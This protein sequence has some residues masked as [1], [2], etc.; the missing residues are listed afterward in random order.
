MTVLQS[1]LSTFKRSRSQS[2]RARRE[3]AA[4]TTSSTEALE[5]RLLLV[6]PITVESLPNAPVT[7]YLDFDGHTE[8]SSEWINARGDMLGSAIVTPAY[9][10]DA[11]GGNFSQAEIDSI[12]EIYERVA[13]DFRPFNINVTTVLPDRPLGFQ[14]GEDLLVS[15]GGTGNWTVPVL[16]TNS[17]NRYRAISGSFANGNSTDPSQTTFAFQNPHQ[18]LGGDFE[19][20]IAASV[21]A[22]IAESMGLEV[23]RTGGP[24]SP[25]LE[26]DA[27]IAP[28]LGDQIVG[29]DTINSNQNSERDIWFNAPGTQSANQDDLALITSAGLVAYRADDFGD[30]DVDSTGIQTTPQTEVITGVIETTTDRDVIAF[31]TAATL[32]NIS[33]ATLDLRTT[34]DPNKTA[35]TNLDPVLT[36]RDQSGAVLQIVD[37]PGDDFGGSLTRTV[38]D[39]TYYLEVSN[40]GEYGNLGR[41]TVSIDGVDVLPGFNNPVALNSKPDAPISLYLAFNGGLIESGNAVLN[42]RVFGVGQRGVQPYDSDGDIFNFTTTEL[43]EMNEIWARVAEDFAPFDVNVTTVRP[44]NFEDGRAMQVIV[45]GDG[46]IYSDATLT[47]LASLAAFSDTALDNTALA[48]PLNI[49]QGAA[50]DAKHVALAASTAFGTMLGLED[51]PLYDVNGNVVN[52]EDPGDLEVGPIMGLPLGSLRDLWV[53][54]AIPSG[55]ADFQDDLATIADITTNGISF[56]VDD[57]RSDLA[58]ATRISIDTGTD[59]ISG[60]IETNDD[61]DLFRFSTLAANATISVKGLDLRDLYASV[62]NP[63]TNLDP[64]LEILDGTGAVIETSDPPNV[65]GNPAR[66]EPSISRNLPAGTYYLRVSNRGEYGNLGQ[67]TITLD[68]VDGDPVTVE[69]DPTTF[70]EID[71]LQMGVGTVNR[72]EGQTPVSPVVVNLTSSDTSELIVPNQVVIP[73]GRVSADF[74]ITLVDD[75]LLDGDQRVSIS[76]IVSGVVNGAAFVTVTDYETIDVSVTPN[77]V[78]EDAGSVS[79][80]LTRSNDDVNAPNHWVAVNNELQEFSPD[81]TF[82]Q[83]IP[84]QWPIGVRPTGEDSHDIVVLEDGRIAVFNGTI[85]AA[86]SIYNPVNTQWQH[87]GPIPGLSGTP[88]DDTVGGIASIGDYVFLTDFETIE[89]DSHGMTRINVVTG[90]VTRFGQGT[91][92]ARLFA[93][94]R[95]TSSDIYEFNALDGSLL[96]TLQLPLIPGSLFRYRPEAIAFDGEALWVL[97]NNGRLAGQHLI[98]V[99]VDSG[100][101][102]DEHSLQGL[103]NSNNFLN[104]LAAM[105]GLLYV[106]T[107]NGTISVPPPTFP[108]FFDVDYNLEVEEYDPVMRRTTGRVISPPALS[109]DFNTGPYYS[110][111]IGAIPSADSI[112]YSLSP[113]GSVREIDASTSVVT[114]A[115]APGAVNDRSDAGLTAISDV[116]YGDVTYNDLVFVATARNAI[117]VFTRAGVQIDTDPTTP[118]VD[119]LT[120]TVF[121]NGDLT[122]ADVPGVAFSDLRFRDVTIGLDGL[123]YGLIDTGDEISVHDPETLVRVRG[124][125]LDTV[126]STIGVSDDTGIYAGASNGRVIQFDANGV[127]QSLLQ[128]S[129]GLIADI[130]VNIGRE[131]LISDVTGSVIITTQEAVA[132]ADI[133]AVTALE[134]TGNVSFVSFGRHPTKSTGDL[135]VSLVSSDLTELTVPDVVV[136]PEGQKSITIQIPVIDD[137]ERDGSQSVTITADSREY[138]SDFEIVVVNDVEN[139]GIDVIPDTVSETA[140]L[141]QGVVRVFRTDVDGPLDFA[142]TVTKNSSGPTA[143]ADNAVSISQIVYEDQ[144]SRVTDVNVALTIEH[145]A[146][147]DLDVF[148]VSPTGTRVALF[149]D[150]SSNESNLTNTTLDDQA[151]LG[152]RQGNAPFTG[153]FIPREALANFTGENPSGA[154]SLEVIDDSITDAGVLVSWSLEISTLGLGALTA[155]LSSSHPTEASIPV[156]VTIPVN[157]AEIFVPLEVFDDDILEGTRAV[158]MSVDS[159]DTTGFILAND[160]VDI[161]DSELLSISLDKNVISESAGLGAIVGTVTRLDTTGA[162]TV[163]LSTSDTTE[164]SVPA[165]VVIPDGVAS[166]TFAVDAVDDAEFDNDQSATVIAS[167]TGYLPAVSEL[168]TIQDQEP[169]LRLS[170]LTPVVPEDAGTITFTVTRLDVNDPS[171]AQQVSLS[172]SDTSELIVPSTVI[173]PPGFLS[174]NFQATVVEDNDL[175]GSQPVTITATDINT[176]T[177]SVN[178]TTFDVTIQDA[179]FVGITVPSGSEKVLENAG[180]GAITATVSISSVGHTAPIVV[181]LSNSDL[182]ELSIPDEVVILVG[183]SST[184][185]D[186][187]VLD[188]PKIDRDQIATITGRVAGYRDG[189]LDITVRDHEPPVEVGPE[190]DTIDPTPV[191]AWAAVDGATRYDLW[192]ND[193]SRKITQLFRLENLP[194]RA[195]IFRDDFELTDELGVG[196][197]DA[198]KWASDNAEVDALA[199]NANGTLSAHLNGNPDGGDLLTSTPIDLSD[200]IGAQ[201][202]YSYQRTGSLEAPGAGQDLILQYRNADGQWL[203]I[204]RQLGVGEDMTVFRTSVVTL[205]EAALHANFAFRFRSIG[206]PDVEPAEGEEATET[207]DD[208]FIDDVEI[209][210]FE[211]FVP[212]QE[213]GVGRYHFWV[214]AYD[215]LEQPG[216]WSDDGRAFRIRTAPVFTSPVQSVFS[217]STNFPQITWTSVVD[218]AR[219]DIWINSVTTGESQVVRQTDLQTTSFASATAGLEGGTYKAWVRAIGPAGV[220]GYWSRSVEFT[221]LQTPENISPSG[222]TFD[223]TPEIRW[224]AVEGATNYDVWVSQRSPGDAR[225]VIRDQ[226]VSGTSLTPA[227]DLENGNFVVWVRAVAADGTKSPWSAPVTFSI[228]GRPIIES[229]TNGSAVSATPTFVWTG[230]NQSD[231]YEVWVNNSAGERVVFDENIQGTSYTVQGTLPADTYRVWV[232]AISEM[233]EKSFYSFAVNFTVVSSDAALEAPH[234]PPR[235]DESLM[236]TSVAIPWADPAYQEATM[237][238]ERT[239]ASNHDESVQPVSTDSDANALPEATVT[240]V[241]M[242]TTD[243]VDTIMADWDASELWMSDDLTSSETS[244]STMAAAAAGVLVAGATVPSRSIDRKKKRR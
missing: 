15:I 109:N 34:Q 145:D 36:L 163:N 187:D 2:R 119:S 218:T 191:F 98:K 64:V 152:I 110:D 11:N 220:Q 89:G 196:I 222:A 217:A 132:T 112:L 128:T 157:Q 58:G 177:P 107:I 204:D 83:T 215:D 57:H 138:V 206:D 190:F 65:G 234:G 244:D 194:A 20:N 224:D 1:L 182:T 170:T 45:G 229:P 198:S 93:I 94:S 155:Q 139:V 88:D 115:I 171:S 135:A 19:V 38:S 21:S 232:R 237:A 85:N 208:W 202:T 69:V 122:G 41:Y 56:R 225:V 161:T 33:I 240:E 124:I 200:E 76:A 207:V 105:N 68:G 78:N 192:A 174:A 129:L 162:L 63:G 236:F 149:A 133:S 127:T 148:L 43:D 231:R 87:L 210:G 77:P 125:D 81:G 193:V 24:N 189:V 140:G 4:A 158:T 134:N 27:L 100:E 181:A 103:Q 195:P 168:I 188:D 242:E 151:A 35:G 183:E 10:F 126:V 17:F 113:S 96:N 104:G 120:T 178:S 75:D 18:G 3:T 131:V 61:V 228:G 67:Y 143:I 219:Y 51:H 47:N 31:T 175:D 92:G 238:V 241:A 130:E 29:L 221:V 7:I 73:G 42:S 84:I 95:S 136:I 199:I 164:I 186:I 46:A 12:Q 111:S 203:Q 55:S 16:N 82:Q 197:F 30:T 216:F 159:V 118:F 22:S 39:G 184:T 101:L 235:L 14:D 5:E 23:H 90:E 180:A 123:L 230:I 243:A 137:H 80:T 205:P 116:V 141:Q 150:L 91:L 102:L 40:R 48:F 52:A 214:R 121:F 227:N 60:V 201:L 8:S 156:T 114:Q 165:T 79:L 153:R 59:R 185:F 74:N 54:A 117:D 154:W 13:E 223:R 213:L 211:S 212:A 66:L 147:P 72:P 160:I 166:V 179:E 99:D 26:G 106:S 32:L 6:N 108:F 169:R 86:L 50:N 70:S 176:V 144:I 9:S 142:T 71:G 209:S 226:F 25:R 97:V 44:F 49:Q 53:N 167:A 233:G 37:T 146:I 172:S 239:E 173:I 28:I 62:T